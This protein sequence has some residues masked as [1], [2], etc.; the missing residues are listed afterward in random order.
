MNRLLILILLLCGTASLLGCGLTPKTEQ[1]IKDNI[2]ANAGHVRDVRLSPAARRIA[3]ANHDLGY[4][5][6]FNEGSIAEIP[7]DVRTRS[8][9]RKGA[10]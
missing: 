5:I 8:E 6:L 10:K 2:A 1:A 4:A 7:S 9:A 3:L